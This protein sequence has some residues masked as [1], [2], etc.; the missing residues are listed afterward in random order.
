[1]LLKKI[2]RN[3]VKICQKVM[4]KY[5]TIRRPRILIG[6]ENLPCI[7]IKIDCNQFINQFIRANTFK[8]NLKTMHPR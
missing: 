1:M 8:R 5:L 7:M 3:G 6:E 4:K 2:P